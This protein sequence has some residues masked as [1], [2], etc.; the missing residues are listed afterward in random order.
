[1]FIIRII[2]LRIVI[3]HWNFIWKYWCRDKRSLASLK[4]RYFSRFRPSRMVNLFAIFP[5]NSVSI[6][7]KENAKSDILRDPLGSRPRN[8]CRCSFPKEALKSRESSAVRRLR[9]RDEMAFPPFYLAAKEMERKL[10]EAVNVNTRMDVRDRKSG[11][12]NW[13]TVSPLY[14]LSDGK[15]E[16]VS[17]LLLSYLHLFLSPLLLLLFLFTSLF[18]ILSPKT[19][20]AF[21]FLI[22]S[23]F[24]PPLPFSL[25][26][27]R[28]ITER[29]ER[30]FAVRSCIWLVI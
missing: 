15:R 17:F 8:S 19:L 11:L 24:P 3:K 5:K 23:S 21:S 22:S 16:R 6:Q 28:F 10:I 14:F 25:T 12:V 26:L 27:F 1:M 4:K 2:G 9:P 7:F 30:S 29:I 13:L 20:F 18:V